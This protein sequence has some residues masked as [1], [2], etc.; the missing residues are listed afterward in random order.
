MTRD[1]HKYRVIY[2]ET[3]GTRKQRDFANFNEALNFYAQYGP[4]RATFWTASKPK[5]A[6][7][8]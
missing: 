7:R 1:A 3:D 8:P 6:R 2:L 4:E 5:K